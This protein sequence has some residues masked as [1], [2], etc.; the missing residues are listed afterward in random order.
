MPPEL[1]TARLWVLRAA[2]LLIAV[3]MGSQ[4]WPL[5]VTSE[6]ARVEHMR[7]VTWAL[8]GALTLLS[9]LGTRYPV[10]ML[11]LLVFELT[12][13]VI[14][15]LSFGLPLWLTDQLTAATSASLVECLLGVVLLPLV[16]PW[17]HV[18]RHYVR[19]PGDGWRRTGFEP[20]PSAPP[21]LRP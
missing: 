2:Y 21:P 12:W 17:G 6:P 11:P 10:K 19:A 4:I 5:I 20:P 9:A 18:W 3:G 1:S 13:K 14:W 8:L 7:G 15:V 16:L